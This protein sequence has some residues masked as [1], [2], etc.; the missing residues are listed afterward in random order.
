M[1]IGPP[2]L[3]SDADKLA[4]RCSGEDATVVG[5]LLRRLRHAVGPVAA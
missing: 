4:V 2:P 5:V 1:F 3:R